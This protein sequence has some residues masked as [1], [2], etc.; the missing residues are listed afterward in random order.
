MGTKA[1]L[2]KCLDKVETKIENIEALAIKKDKEI[3]ELKK[4]HEEL[5]KVLYEK[6]RKLDDYESRCPKVG[7][8]KWSEATGSGN[9]KWGKKYCTNGV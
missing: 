9:N 1:E 2:L 7:S 8:N 4:Q 5:Y 3:Q 6:K